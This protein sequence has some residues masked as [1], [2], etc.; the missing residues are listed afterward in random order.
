MQ[1]KIGN[2]LGKKTD[3][4]KYKES[5]LLIDNNIGIGV[6]IELENIVYF[7]HTPGYPGIFNLWQ[8]VEDGSLRSG[9]EFIFDGPLKGI[10]ITDALDVMGDFLGAYLRDGKPPKVTDRCSVHIHLDVSDMDK[11]QLNNLVAIYYLVE[12]VLFQYV[13]PIRS[14]NNYCRPLTDST[15]KYV[16]KKLLKNDNDYDLI[17]LVK[18][19]CEKYSA[20][21]VLPISTF[22]S[23][24]FRHHQGTT[25]MKDVLNWINIIMALKIAAINYPIKQL[26]DLYK[27]DGAIP[28]LKVIMNGSLL[29]EDSTI[30][31]IEDIELL[32]NKGVLDL[33]E[34]FYLDELQDLTKSKRAS[35][36][37][38]HLLKFKTANSL[39]GLNNTGE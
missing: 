31:K 2:I 11:D 22:G 5:S 34:I 20:L 27:T 21:N 8:A 15:F 29:S 9:T 24:E 30:E 38:T 3:Y 14:K 16:F 35:R 6:E 37:N 7:S 4:H 32:M 33:T 18:Q 12:R 1:L 10:N 13:D 25:N 23:A 28:T 26:L 36:S 39:V 17:Y 19:L